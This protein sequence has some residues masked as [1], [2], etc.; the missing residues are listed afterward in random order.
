[1]PVAHQPSD[2]IVD[3]GVVIVAGENL[4]VFVILC[5]DPLEASVELSYGVDR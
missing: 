3:V 2:Q 4:V 5:R 1:M